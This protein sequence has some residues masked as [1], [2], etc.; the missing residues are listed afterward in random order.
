MLSRST[1]E[2]IPLPG[3]LDVHQD[4]L[5]WRVGPTSSHFVPAAG[6][7]DNV[8]RLARLEALPETVA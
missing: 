6:C 5:R 4:D 8:H 3:H 1:R 2:L 7:G